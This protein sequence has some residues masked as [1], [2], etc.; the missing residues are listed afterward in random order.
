MARALG[1]LLGDELVLL[2][3]LDHGVQRA[4][5]ELDALVLVPLAH[6]A[7]HLVR[8]HGPL[9]EAGEHGQREW[10][11]DFP[12][13]HAAAPCA[14]SCRTT[15]LRR[16]SGVRHNTRPS[17]LVRTSP[18][19]F[20]ARC[21]RQAMKPSGRSRTAPESST[22][23][24]D[25]HRPS[26]SIRSAPIRWTASGAAERHAIAIAARAQPPAPGPQ[27]STRSRP[28]RS[29]EEILAPRCSKTTCGARV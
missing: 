3:R 28:I 11:R 2:Q 4:I 16:L 17:T 19:A 23:K 6:R 27:S 18:G 13:A 9:V 8:V 20:T 15:G 25:C 12:L 14:V 10:V 1:L 5:V 21:E 24:A 22:P 29:R 7:R 26:T